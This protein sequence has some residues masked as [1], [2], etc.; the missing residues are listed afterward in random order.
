MDF[1]VRVY[2]SLKRYIESEFALVTC[3]FVNGTY[4]FYVI[5]VFYVE[6]NETKKKVKWYWL[7][8]QLV[9]TVW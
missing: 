1:Y 8:D 9:V 3:M 6:M 5:I 4:N 2:P 7:V